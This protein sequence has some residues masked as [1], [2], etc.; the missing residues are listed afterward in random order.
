MQRHDIAIIGAGCAGLTAALYLKRA[1][2]DLVLLEKGAPGGKLLT[3]NEIANYPGFEKVPGFVLAQAIVKSAADSGVEMTSA[4]VKSVSKAEGGFLVDTDEESYLVKAVLVAT[5]LSN[6]PSIKGEKA[7]LA[8]GVSY[9]ATCDGPLYRK[10]D[11]ALIGEGERSLAE[12]LYLSPLVNR[13]LYLTPEKELMGDPGSVASLLSRPNVE[14]VYEAKALEIKGEGHVGSLVYETK[15][16]EK[17]AAVSAVFPLL[18]EKSASSFLSPLNLTLKNGFVPV[19][20]SLMSAVPG[21]F[22]AGDIVSKRLRQAITAA[23]DGA[24]ASA[25]IIAYLREGKA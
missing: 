17:E 2:K 25:G 13:L 15:G 11:V 12:A 19:D 7:L 20:S 22:A 16:K 6:V 8:R 3:V 21:L 9:C 24:N 4:S 14:I 23:G 5:G 18:G 10:K 1:S